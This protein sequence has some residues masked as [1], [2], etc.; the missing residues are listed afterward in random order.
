MKNLTMQTM[1]FL[2]EL[3]RTMRTNNKL[4]TDSIWPWI[5]CRTWGKSQ[6]HATIQHHICFLLF[7]SFPP[8]PAPPLS[9]AVVLKLHLGA[10]LKQITCWVMLLVCD[11]P[12]LNEAQE[13]GFL[14]VLRWC[15]HY[16]PGD[17]TFWTT[18]L[19]CFSFFTFCPSG[20]LGS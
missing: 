15:C 7:I 6:W 3:E 5:Q 9:R 8:S 2:K 14:E 20:L 10:F 18:A 1:P 11:S 19:D 16:W 4:R 12:G 17:Y 13:H